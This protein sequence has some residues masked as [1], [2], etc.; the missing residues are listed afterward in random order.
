M[1]KKMKKISKHNIVS[2]K[3]N[4]SI[5]SYKGW[6]MHCNAHNLYTKH[7]EPLEVKYA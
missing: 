4:A 5:Q 3:D 2:D 1:V 6:L 7:I